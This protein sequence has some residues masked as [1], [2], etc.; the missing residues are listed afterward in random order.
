MDYVWQLRMLSCTN[1][2]LRDYLRSQ[3]GCKH[4]RA[5]AKSI[6]ACGLDYG[7]IGIGCCASNFDCHKFTEHPTRS[8]LKGVVPAVAFS[9]LAYRRY[10]DH[11]LAYTDFKST[12][13]TKDNY[14]LYLGLLDGPLYPASVIYCFRERLLDQIEGLCIDLGREPP[15][16]EC[17]VG[18]LYPPIQGDSFKE[19]RVF[20]FQEWIITD[21]GRCADGYMEIYP[22]Q[23]L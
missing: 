4:W 23:R 1:T 17:E 13:K 2:T 21:R 20:L 11:S 8:T 12:A 18:P 6:F 9:D 3:S 16:K 19:V 5:V 7:Y 10:Y 14:R 22:R 15:F